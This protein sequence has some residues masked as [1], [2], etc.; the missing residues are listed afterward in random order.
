M[1]ANATEGG[2]R[3]LRAAQTEAALKEAAVRVFDRVGY[4]NAK[5]TDITAEAGRSAGSFY[6]HFA[7]KEQLLE[8]L[9]QDLMD[10]GDEE[11]AADAAHSPDFTSRDAVRW[12]V[13][14]SWALG[15]EQ[16]PVFA[17]LRQAAL[18]DERFARRLTELMSPVVA[19]LAGH[20]AY[21][22]AAGRTLPGPPEDVARAMMALVTEYHA[23]WLT[24]PARTRLPA[25]AAIDLVTNLI[26]T[27]IGGDTAADD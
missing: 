9:L 22:A 10:H 11:V 19:D 24:Q 26:F 18:V 25:D 3:K 21:V 5:I 27:G 14:Q 7:D 4:L 8:A 17:A 13:A 23:T 1:G 6:S 12:H 15:E 20:F 2:V 16:A